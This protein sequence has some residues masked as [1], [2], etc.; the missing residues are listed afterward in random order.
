MQHR[1]LT[2][3]APPISHQSERATPSNT[4]DAFD[5][6]AH[7]P[8]SN[9]IIDERAVALDRAT[10]IA[11]GICS[12]LTGQQEPNGAFISAGGEK[13]QHEHYAHSF[14]ALALGMS[15]DLTGDPEMWAAAERATAFTLS[16]PRGLR[17]R[18][19]FNSLALLLLLEQLRATSSG[20]SELREKLELVVRAPGFLYDGR[21]P[22][23]N[24]WIAMRAAC[25]AI[26]SRLTKDQV[27]ARRANAL[28]DR[29]LEWQLPDGIFADYPSDIR[30]A[31]S[32]F[33][34]PMT[35]HAKTCAMLAL[36]HRYLGRQDIRA[37]AER[38]LDSLISLMS[39]AGDC[40]YYGRS[41]NSLF[42]LA[43]TYFALREFAC[44]ESGDRFGVAAELI[45]NRILD[46]RQPDGHL[47]LVPDRAEYARNGWDVYYHTEVY[48]AYAAAL[49]L[50]AKRPVIIDAERKSL[51]SVIPGTTQMPDAGLVAVR[52]SRFF[53]AFSSRGQCVLAGSSLFCDM[54]YSGLQPL[55]VEVD[56]KLQIPEPPL[57]WTKP[58]NK[59]EAVNPQR[60]GFVPYI[61]HRGKSYCVRRFAESGTK[62]GQGWSLIW[63]RGEPVSLENP[64][65]PQKAL[66]R[67]AGA[68]SSQH[69]LAFTPKALKGM[70]IV[71]IV[72]VF[73]HE[74]AI[75]FLDGFSGNWASGAVW[76]GPSARLMPDACLEVRRLCGSTP[77]T[78]TQSVP[79]SC[80]SA[81]LFTGSTTADPSPGIVHAFAVCKRE[82]AVTLDFKNPFSGTVRCGNRSVH[83]DLNALESSAR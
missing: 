7:V 6:S 38:G 61:L 70:S 82:T 34:T 64:S 28:L 29:V 45:L 21:R 10:R 31:K 53:A 60:I 77:I 50:L 4:A 19:E 83:I 37:V 42:G 78:A 25:F 48:N 47:R 67:L 69:D 30:R 62:S 40:L 76:S 11:L 55:M 16:L 35:Y 20:P 26:H 1:A 75:V 17:S 73:P 33:A 71:R 39:D 58:G 66:R 46:R 43:A 59:Q 23:S 5:R 12:W 57:N 13:V 41:A 56:G 74:Q 18:Q 54:R 65:T 14:G 79:T 27:S 72:V 8:G 80:G 22:V 9:G 81:K 49:L 68:V 51:S 32:E 63:G 52:G 36:S 15:A 3:T 44:P 24:N 2:Y